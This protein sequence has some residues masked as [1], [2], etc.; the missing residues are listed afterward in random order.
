M[1]SDDSEQRG[2]VHLRVTTTPDEAAEFLKRLSEDDAF[3][4]DYEK[5]PIKVLAEYG[6]EIGSEHVPEGITAP[7]KDVLMSVREQLDTE[8]DF[9]PAMF[10]FVGWPMAF[11][12]FLGLRSF[13]SFGNV[14]PPSDE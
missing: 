7:P 8:R 4:A 2:R 10:S 13:G 5:D 3:R 11:F 12:S 9:D 1:S 6:I 14:R